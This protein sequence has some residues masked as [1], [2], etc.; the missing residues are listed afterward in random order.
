METTSQTPVAASSPSAAIWPYQL[1]S[2]L[3]TFIKYAILLLVLLIVLFPI[4]WMVNTS[5]K[6]RLELTT[7]PPTLFPQDF[8]WF[9]YQD[10]FTNNQIPR[11]VLN[12]VIVVSISTF[13]SLVMG[14]LAGYSLARFPFTP[15]FKENISF[16]IL[17]T[18]MV[19]PIVTIIPVF[20]IFKD[21]HILNSYPGLIIVYTGFTLP[22]STWMMRAFVRE[23]PVDLEEAAMVD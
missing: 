20:L 17:S 23:V 6:N 8:T 9:N 10:A 4:Y 15:R 2:V 18:R 13:I 5:F 7:Y 16:W 1:R 22:F 11:Y 3:G 21:L 14:T 19:P 12:S